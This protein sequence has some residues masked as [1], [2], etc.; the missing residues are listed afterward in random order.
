MIFHTAYGVALALFIFTLYWH[1]WIL[2]AL[3]ELVVL[4]AFVLAVLVWAGPLSG[5]L[6]SVI[7]GW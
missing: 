2:R 1:P 7:Y 6:R 5:P 4:G 3:A